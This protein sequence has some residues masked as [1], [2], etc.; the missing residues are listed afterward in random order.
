MSP[1]YTFQ[2]P[3]TTLPT[4]H[5]RRPNILR[6][7]PMSIGFAFS[8]GGRPDNGPNTIEK[9]K[10]KQTFVRSVVLIDVHADKFPTPLVDSP[11]SEIRHTFGLSQSV[12]F[13]PFSTS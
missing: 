4:E 11:A 7:I 10:S 6:L 8:S 2:N 1:F 3:I 13:P 9:L 12:D 5:I